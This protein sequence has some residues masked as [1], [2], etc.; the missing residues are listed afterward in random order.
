MGFT[1]LTAATLGFLGL[2]APAPAPEWGRMISESR[3]FLQ[4]AYDISKDGEIAAHLGEVMWMMGDRDA[5]V[6]LWDKARKESPDDPVLKEA[7]RR[8]AP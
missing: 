5:A 3:E 1:I 6:A 7:V 8:F 4:R 2:G